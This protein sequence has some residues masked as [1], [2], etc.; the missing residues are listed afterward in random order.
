MTL[1]KLVNTEI[2]ELVVSDDTAVFTGRIHRQILD[3]QNTC[4]A[5]GSHLVCITSYDLTAVQ[6]PPFDR[7]V[8]NCIGR[9]VITPQST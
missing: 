1:T 4:R 3:E 7:C 2:A 9:V 8:F 6:R 5:V